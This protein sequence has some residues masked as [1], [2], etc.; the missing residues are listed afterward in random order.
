MTAEDVIAALGLTPL[1]DA[2]LTAT[3]AKR[4]EYDAARS[5]LVDALMQVAD[6]ALSPAQVDALESAIVAASQAP[7]IVRTRSAL[8]FA[9]Y[10]F[11]CAPPSRVIMLRR[12]KPVATICSGVALGSRS[13]A[14]CS[15]VNWS[16]RLLALNALMT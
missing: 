16:K 11:G 8:Y 1:F 6:P 10:S 3:N 13:P 4:K 5:A 7:P 12:L 9:R 15:M 14:S 2:T